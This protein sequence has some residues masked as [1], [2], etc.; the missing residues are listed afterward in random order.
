ML[1]PLKAL[2]LAVKPEITAIVNINPSNTNLTPALP[3]H[4]Q[5]TMIQFLNLPSDDAELS[6]LHRSVIKKMQK[7]SAQIEALENQCISEKDLAITDIATA[8]FHL[9]ILTALNRTISDRIGE[10]IDSVPDSTFLDI[11][12]H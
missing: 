12:I 4:L 11:S 6:L 10:Y 9:G 5:N 1:I 8:H 3:R 2:A 7:V